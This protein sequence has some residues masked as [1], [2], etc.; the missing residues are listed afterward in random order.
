M[1]DQLKAVVSVTADTSGLVRGVEGAMAKIG[2][3]G[4]S[5]SIMAG[6]QAGQML[7]DGAMRAWRAISDR[8]EELGKLAT[9][10]TPAGSMAQYQRMI[11][12]LAA[13]K[14]IAQAIAPA[15]V[16]IELMRAQSAREQAA[17][18]VGNAGQIGAG[19]NF[20]EALKVTMTEAFT[21]LT[22]G[23][24]MA[25]GIAG[26]GQLDLTNILSAG[27]ATAF[28]RTGATDTIAEAYGR[29]LPYLDRII[30]KMGG[31]P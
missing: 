1:A 18:I 10:L 26:G 25:L 6:L 15:Q 14:Q 31:E 17:S 4:R 23:I 11:A 12:E 3:I 21:G 9:E 16:G 8:S 29:I 2:S 7:L 19:M 20:V 30:E 24:L 28:E 13:N 27:T 5:V 22:D